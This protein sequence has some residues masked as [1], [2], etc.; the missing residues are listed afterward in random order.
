VHPL[1]NP[2]WHSLTG[3]QRRLAERVGDAAR[4]DAEVAPFAAV[5][6][7]AGTTAWADLATLVGPGGLAVLFRDDLPPP[8]GWDELLRLSALQMVADR[9]D[10]APAPRAAQLGPG[11]LAEVR[12]LVD[13]TEPGPFGTRTM[14]LGTYI[15]IRVGGDLVALAGERMRFD[16]HTEISA[17]CTRP[18]HRGEGLAAELVRDL[19][20]R[21]TGRG[22][23]AF[24]H[25]LDDNEAAIGLYRALGFAERRRL[26]VIGVRPPRAR[27]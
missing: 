5:P 23:T 26:E 3:P 24:L 20:G 8:D 10:D 1:D 27:P 18:D 25:V 19:V 17:V 11:D 22:D 14:E 6:D 2:V 4:Y 9:V 13:M 16:G 15:G 12:T 21:I 7:E